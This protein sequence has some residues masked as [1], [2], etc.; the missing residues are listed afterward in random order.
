MT[1]RPI[2]EK[3]KT[4]PRNAIREIMELAGGR[5]DIIHLEVGEP[6]FS[7]PDHIVEAAYQ[8]LKEGWT[9]YVPGAGIPA[10]REQIA[11]RAS[12]RAGRA[13]EADRVVVTVGAVGALYTAILMLC[14]AGDEVLIPDP[15]WPNYASIPHIVGATPV[16]YSQ[17]ASRRFLPN[18]DEVEAKV[19]AKT[20]AIM[21]NTP[22]N[23]TG[24]VFPG[25]T[26]R[27]LV[28]VARRHDLYLI[29]DEVYEDFV[30][31]GEHVSASSFGLDEQVFV[32]S[33]VS[34]S[35]A[36][37]GWRLGYLICPPGMSDL[38]TALQDPTVASAAAPTQ[39]AAEAAL[40]SSQDC[41]AEAAAIFR[42][43]RDVLLQVL[44]NTGLMLAEPDGAFYALVGI[45]DRHPDSTTFAKALIA[46]RK[47]ATVPGLT[48]GPSCDKA[49]RVAFTI[50]D[51]VL[52]QGL[53]I[54][55]DYVEGG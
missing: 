2:S 30:Y 13:V 50:D 20:K 21:I 31:E 49:V 6:D 22:G 26:M 11:R 37:T 1:T 25:E 19:T 17:L 18:L 54:L 10:L 43:R 33:G 38:A 9:K 32:V 29:S 34:K 28:D 48:F 36:M 12:G 51:E 55:R 27:G 14:D 24:V 41:V 8:A 16:R 46:E 15:C 45:G 3:A 44:G 5:K 39:K 40:A 47:V 52:R 42:R 35:Y 23:P 4:M 53:E 7:T